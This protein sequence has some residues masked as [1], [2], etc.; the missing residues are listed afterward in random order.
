LQICDTAECNSAL[1]A[2]TAKQTGEW[3]AEAY[4]EQ[5][6]PDALHIC[7]GHYGL[8]GKSEAPTR[9]PRFGYPLEMILVAGSFYGAQA[10]RDEILKHA[11]YDWP[12]INNSAPE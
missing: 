11:R 3:E 12:Q 10:L 7:R 8:R 5:A 9:P 2:W 4:Q 6:L 1:R